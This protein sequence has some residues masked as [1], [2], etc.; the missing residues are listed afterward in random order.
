MAWNG[1]GSRIA[2]VTRDNTFVVWDTETAEPI[3]VAARLRDG[4]SVTLS[5]SGQLLAGDP[6][7]VDQ[8]F[9]Y[10]VER[11]DGKRERLSHS[12]FQELAR[13]ITP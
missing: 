10:V 2:T 3:W 4:R 1:D 5:G 7:I 11:S 9:V 8:E 13:Q 12:A 6:E